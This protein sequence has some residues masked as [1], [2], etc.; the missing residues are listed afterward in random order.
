MECD[1]MS[2][3]G[4]RLL[5]WTAHKRFTFATLGRVVRGVTRWGV[6]VGVW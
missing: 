6:G 2:Q 5:A 3:V 1:K 4:I